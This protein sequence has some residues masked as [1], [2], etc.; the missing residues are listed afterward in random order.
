MTKITQFE[1]I[2]FE[3]PVVDELGRKTRREIILLYALGEDGMIYE[4]S[5]GKWFALPIDEEH[6][7]VLSPDPTKERKDDG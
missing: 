3:G 5:A 6:M 4:M 1:V 2:H 7:R